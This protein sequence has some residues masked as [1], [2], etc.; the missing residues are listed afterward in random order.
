MTNK[1]FLSGILSLSLFLTGSLT[2][3]QNNTEQLNGIF[4]DLSTTKDGKGRMTITQSPFAYQLISDHIEINKKDGVT[5]YRIQIGQWSGTNSREKAKAQAADFK[6]KF[7][8]FDPDIIY[9]PYDAPY[10]KLRVGDYRNRHEAFEIY[11]QIKRYYPNTAYIVKT[12]I[13]YPKLD[14]PVIT[15]DS[16]AN[17][18]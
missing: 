2:M 12:R 15:V 3:A 14:P 16:T 8:E 5:G 9:I 1:I 17:K 4:Y 11:N 6:E 13:N 7:P 10:Y 18:Q